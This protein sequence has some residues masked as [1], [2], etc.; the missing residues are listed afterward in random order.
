MNILMEQN[1]QAGA[2]AVIRKA[3]R[4]VDIHTTL[5]IPYTLEE[6]ADLAVKVHADVIGVADDWT[7]NSVRKY[8]LSNE[9][10]DLLVDSVTMALDAYR[11]AGGE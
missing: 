9:E 8:G 10:R 2:R 6:L 7:I 1:V 11:K 3:L 5:A 4:M